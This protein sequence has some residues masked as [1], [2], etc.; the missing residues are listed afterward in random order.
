M[1]I[2]IAA[3]L[4]PIPQDPAYHEFADTRGCGPIPNCFNVLSNVGFV[5]AGF[6]GL[7]SVYRWPLPLQPA[8]KVFWWGIL[9]IGPGSAWYHWAPD[10]ARLVW[11]RL[12]MTVA[13]MGL[14]AAVLEDQFHLKGYWLPLLVGIGL[15]S[16]GVWL[17]LD[18]LRVYGL[19]QFLPPVLILLIFYQFPP[20]TI[21]RRA[22]YYAFGF[23]CLAKGAEFFDRQL[24]ALTGWISG[25][26]L[27]H[28]LA[29]VAVTWLIKPK[30]D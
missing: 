15:A 7:R 14:F 26:S 30:I 17:I 20:A 11:D 19:V 18:D 9:L 2:A 13:F 23:Y 3:M 24:W 21:P 28:L 25:H 12:P 1:A 5:V 22:L 27:K 16:I 6:F 8:M 29:A 10:D 4:G